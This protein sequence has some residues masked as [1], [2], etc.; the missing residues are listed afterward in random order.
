MTSNCAF[1][2]ELGGWSFSNGR[3]IAGDASGRRYWRV[4]LAGGGTAVVCRYPD[5][6]R[7]I[8]RR[9]TDVLRWLEDRGLPVPHL[10]VGDGESTWLLLEDL[11][12]TDAEAALARLDP[13]DRLRLV[14]GMIR[15]LLELAVVPGDR[16]PPWNVPLDESFLRWELA[17]F[18]MW[19]LQAGSDP[20][21]WRRT[22]QW[23][24]HLAAAVGA[25]P[26]VICFRDYHVNNLLVDHDR[27]VCVIDVQDLRLGPDT[28]DL[29]SLLWDRSMPE[30][31]DRD[32]RWRAARI[33]ADRVGAEPGWEQRLRET[34]LQ[35][36]LKVLG[37]F[38]F[39]RSKGLQ[40]YARWIPKT[41]RRAANLAEALGGPPEIIGF[42]LDLIEPGGVDV[43]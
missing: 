8:V 15:P 34:A 27:G 29:A 41:A 21:R 38:C 17:G 7:R 10:M 13:D 26:S 33:W 5:H 2:A 4:D 3:P 20:D 32:A 30:L 39:L 37:T 36:S 22:R 35:R 18:E 40:R 12:P 16:L 23:L 19:T 25:H 1:P 6:W 24:D 11:G 42:L 9:D 14:E 28:Y 31:L 43:R